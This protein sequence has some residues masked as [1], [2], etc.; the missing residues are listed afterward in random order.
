MTTRR[1]FLAGLIA[2]T[3]LPKQTWA[4]AGSPAFLAAAKLPDASYA[5]FGLNAL[6]AQIFQIPLPS[7]G[8]AACGHPTRPEAVAF[9]RRPGRFALVIDC[10]TGET[11]KQMN[12]PQGR[13]FYGHGCFI[14]AGAVLCTT[15]NDIET[16]QGVIGLWSRHDGYRR[17]GEVSSGG[18]GPHE[19]KTLA[20][21]QGMVVANGGIRTHPDSGRQKLN[22]DSMRPNLT[23]LNPAG[24]ITAQVVLPPELAQNSIRHIDVNASN[25]VAF[26]MQW[27]GD[28]LD[29]PALAGIATPDKTTFLSVPAAQQRRLKNYIGSIAFSN[30]GRKVGI[31]APRGGLLQIFDGQT[32]E[33]LTSQRRPDISG[34]A[35]H[36][37]GFVATDGNGV[38]FQIAGQTKVKLS[39][40]DLHWDNHLVKIGQL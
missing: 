21:G 2:A 37:D 15:E 10:V 40:A 23:F 16:G 39:H 12:V 5:L 38:M 33:L 7:R 17:I 31:T 13:H 30:D 8:H 32:A 18:I 28:A 24:E 6:G 4:D 35:A 11:V 22:L 25:Q 14:N 20:G 1:G 9:A 29:A 27:Q 19:I 34:I 36:A 3:A 26:G